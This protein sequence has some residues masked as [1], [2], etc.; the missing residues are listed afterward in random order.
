MSH[1]ATEAFTGHR[2]VKA[3]GAE[4]R[5]AQ[6]FGLAARALYRANMMVTAT[7]SMM[8]PIM[9]LLGGVAMAVGALVRQ[10]AKS[11]GAR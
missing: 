1:V 6:R 2:I 3:F 8:P 10:P 5:E 4:D 11:R 7:V 9:E